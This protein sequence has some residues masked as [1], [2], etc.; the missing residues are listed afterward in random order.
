MEFDPY[1]EKI[2]SKEDIRPLL[3]QIGFLRCCIN[4]GELLT[5]KEENEI[6]ELV[7]QFK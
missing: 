4:S 1:K 6:S 7:K 2:Y 3:A 5:D